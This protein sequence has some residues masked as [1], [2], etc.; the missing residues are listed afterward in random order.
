MINVRNLRAR[1][2]RQHVVTDFLRL[3]FLFG[4]NHFIWAEGQGIVLKILIIFDKIPGPFEPPFRRRLRGKMPL[5]Y[6]SVPP[7]GYS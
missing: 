1:S 3:V 2:S 7:I 5:P 6:T 4:Q